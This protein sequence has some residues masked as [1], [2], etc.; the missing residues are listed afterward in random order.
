MSPLSFLT[1]TTVA[2]FGTRFPTGRGP[3]SVPMLCVG[4]PAA[5]GVDAVS[6]R[7]PGPDGYTSKVRQTF[8]GGAGTFATVPT[9]RLHLASMACASR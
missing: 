9:G 7:P 6:M 2:P 1:E 8:L 5:A 4:P 3:D